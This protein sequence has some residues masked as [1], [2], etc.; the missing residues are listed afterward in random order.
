MTTIRMFTFALTVAAVA[1]A[2]SPVHSREPHPERPFYNHFTEEDE[3]RIGAAMAQRIE[4]NGVAVPGPNGRAKMA[5]V[6]RNALLEAYLE[7]I[8]AHLGAASQRPGITYTVRVIDAPRIVNATSIPGGHIYIYSGLLDFVQ[9]ESELAA[10]L[11][12]E[13]GHVVAGHS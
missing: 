2:P 5:R 8:A 4:R 9:S 6:E 7:S 3:A 12:H 11:G 10:V 13:I 1:L